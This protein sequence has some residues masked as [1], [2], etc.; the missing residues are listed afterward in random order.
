MD[1]KAASTL[2]HVDSADRT[3]NLNSL[4]SVSFLRVQLS[5]SPRAGRVDEH[6]AI[7]FSTRMCS[8]V[9]CVH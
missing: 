7:V 5:V 2:M 8:V 4:G 9:R 6:H 3:F 1:V